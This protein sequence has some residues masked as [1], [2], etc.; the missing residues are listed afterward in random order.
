MFAVLRSAALLCIALRCSV[1]SHVGMCLFS[2]VFLLS[3]MAVS[4]VSP[5]S[6]STDEEYLALHLQCGIWSSVL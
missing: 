4:H 5:N 1:L 2:S 6:Q 3:A